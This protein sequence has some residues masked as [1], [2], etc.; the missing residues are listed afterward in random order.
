MDQGLM[1]QNNEVTNL[2]IVHCNGKF[3]SG[4]GGGGRYSVNVWVG[5]VCHWD[6]ETLFLH[7]TMFS[8]I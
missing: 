4:G 3:V 6:S 7:Q 8:C 5:V 2:R 1:D